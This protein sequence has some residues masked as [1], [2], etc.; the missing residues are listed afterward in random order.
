MAR[1]PTTGEI[2]AASAA[3]EPYFD[4]VGKVVHA[5][6]HLHEELGKL[7]CEVAGI[8]ESLGLAIWHSTLNDRTQR[9]MLEAAITER[10]HDADW[11]DAHP[12][13][14]KGICWI[15]TKANDLGDK[16]NTTIHAPCSITLG[17]TELEIIPYF[18]SRNPR[19][20]RLRGKDI[21]AEFDWYERSADALKR[22][23][24]DAQRALWG[25]HVP[26]PD[27]PQMPV[28]ELGPAR[29]AP[30]RKSDAK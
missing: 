7:F 16:R 6:N 2:E 22:H 30:H 20:R 8:S 4:A 5:W 24:K 29:K 15:L 23:V 17:D 26:W 10:S 12:G 21:L 13:A 1:L 18:W 9:L 11:S 19:A 3:F 27:T 25:A 28:L 14:Y